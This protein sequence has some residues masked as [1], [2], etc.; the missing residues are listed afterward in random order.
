LQVRQ[1]FGAAAYDSS[2]MLFTAVDTIKPGDVYMRLADAVQLLEWAKS[3]SRDGPKLKLLLPD[4]DSIEPFQRA[5]VRKGGVAG[6]LYYVF[7]VA[8]DQ[9]TVTAAPLPPAARQAPEKP[10]SNAL[11][12]ELHQS[13]CRPLRQPDER[14]DR[15]SQLDLGLGLGHRREHDLALDHLARQPCSQAARELPEIHVLQLLDQ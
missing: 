6:Q 1:V 11:A 5:T 14:G 15:Q 10:P 8:I 7:A 3:T 2:S 13:F 4:D 12:G 9:P